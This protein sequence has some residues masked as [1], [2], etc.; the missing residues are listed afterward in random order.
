VEEVKRSGRGVKYGEVLIA[1]LL[2]ADDI[3]LVADSRED[4]EFLMNVVWEYSKKW[5]FL[6]NLDKSAVIT[7]EENL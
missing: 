3:V 6:F 4:L 2:F 5:R 7:F 1:S